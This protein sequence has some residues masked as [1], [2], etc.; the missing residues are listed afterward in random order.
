MKKK[1]KRGGSS[2]D[3]KVK[4]AVRLLLALYMAQVVGKGMF[5]TGSFTVYGA[6]QA[7]VQEAEVPGPCAL[8]EVICDGEAA[9]PLTIEEKI[10]ATFPEDP[11]TAVAIAKAESGLAPGAV[12]DMHLTFFHEGRLMGMSCGVFQVR[13]LPGRPDCET[14]KN[15]DA[16]LRKARSLYEASGW[17]PWSAWTSGKYRQYL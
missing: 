2:F 4:K 14:L 11:D 16:N 15:V 17:Q 12:G 9:R 3:K 10:R 7:S 1:N 5:G 13:V 6:A 8:D